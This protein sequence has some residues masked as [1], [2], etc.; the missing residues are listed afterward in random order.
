MMEN[1]H[2]K[3]YTDEECVNLFAV[4]FPDGFAGKD[5]LA[6]I[7]PQGYPQSTLRFAFHPT[8]DQV[9]W[10]RVQFHRNIEWL[11]WRDK[12]RPPEPEPSLEEVAAA[13]EDPPID[14]EREIGELVGMCLWD[15]FSNE[16]DVVGLDGRL[17]DIGSWRG[18]GG[19]IA[20]EL[21]R[22]MGEAKYDYMDFYMGTIWVSQ[23][24]DLTPVYEMIFRRLNDRLLNWRFRFPELGLVE[25]PSDKPDGAR[26]RRIEKMKADLKKAHREAI[27]DSKEQPVPV[28]VLAYR[29]VYG[30][31]P[32]GWPPW[33]FDQ[34]ED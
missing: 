4:L 9:Y 2:D 13:Y 19:F 6:E 18:T 32:H 12:D 28:I 14:T 21:N 33:E 34:R 20:D 26:S 1:E 7:A 3:R 29:N 25:F 5:V 15:T 17:V 31:F 22:Q 23:R 27:E 16:H 24:A 30:A 11:P 10:E 8:V